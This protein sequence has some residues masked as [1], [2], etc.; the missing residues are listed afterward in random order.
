MRSSL[1]SLCIVAVICALAG[2]IAGCATPPPISNQPSNPVIKAVASD[3]TIA[4]GL[5]NAAFNIDQ[6]I[7]IGVLPTGDPAASCLHGFMQQ[8]G[9]EAV[10][11][12]V[13]AQS[14]T[15]KVTDVISAGSVL[16]IQAAQAQGTALPAPPVGCDAILGKFV[17]QAVQAG[18][19]MATTAIP[20]AG[21]LM[22][23]IKAK[24]Q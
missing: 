13:A 7:A 8:A 18:F 11:G 14:F 17:R 20:G 9:L 21:P 16:Y 3:P 23:V 19:S 1:S 6:A 4:T 24:L 2:C 15:P 10:P 12:Q 5:Q 22:G